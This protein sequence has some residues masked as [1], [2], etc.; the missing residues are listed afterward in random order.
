MSPSHGDRLPQ[1]KLFAVDHR[2][3]HFTRSSFRGLASP[4]ATSTSSAKASIRRSV[5]AVPADA[6]PGHPTPHAVRRLLT[7]PTSLL[8]ARIPTHRLN[9]RWP[10]RQSL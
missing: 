3:Q 6:R 10:D 5:P 7:H 2:L 9:A 1:R 8:L 4:I